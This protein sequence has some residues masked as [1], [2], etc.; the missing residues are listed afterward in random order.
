MLAK[1]FGTQ[2]PQR[3]HGLCLMFAI[4]CPH[5]A[6]CRKYGEELAVTRG[7]LLDLRQCWE[8]E[9]QEQITSRKDLAWSFW[10]ITF[11]CDVR[12]MRTFVASWRDSSM[13]ADNP[14]ASSMVSWLTIPPT[15]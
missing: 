10:A 8:Q 3:K 1:V 2:D 5:G 7:F 9:T 15:I 13:A 14:R 4:R 11:L 6:H 12:V